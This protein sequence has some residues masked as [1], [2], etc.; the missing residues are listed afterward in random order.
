MVILLP[1]FTG[2]G[3]AFSSVG[4]GI[5]DKDMLVY[6]VKLSMKVD[7]IFIYEEEAKDG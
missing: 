4:S 5:K 6:I 7:G 3:V 2:G 1:L